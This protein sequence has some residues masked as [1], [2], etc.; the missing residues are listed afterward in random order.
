MFQT[1]LPG[2]YIALC[3]FR[4]PRNGDVDCMTTAVDELKLFGI[5]D[6]ESVKMLVFVLVLVLVPAFEMLVAM[7]VLVSV[8]FS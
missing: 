7:L 2:H 5:A 6:D 4:L 8:F 1:L 3:A